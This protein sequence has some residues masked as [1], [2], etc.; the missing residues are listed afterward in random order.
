[1]SINHIITQ[2]ETPVFV[3]QPIDITVNTLTCN[4]L[5]VIGPIS[6]DAYYE[7][8]NNIMVSNQGTRNTCVGLL[9]QSS[10]SNSDNTILGYGSG[11]FIASNR[12]TVLGSSNLTGA[13]ATGAGDKNIIIGTNNYN[14]TTNPGTGNITIGSNCVSNLSMNN[15]L[16]IGDTVST[17]TSGTTRIAP[18]LL[19]NSTHDSTSRLMAHN[20]STGEV[21]VSSTLP[22]KV[23]SNPTTGGL[24]YSTAGT[25]LVVGATATSN[26]YTGTLVFQNIP[27]PVAGLSFINLTLS[28]NKITDSSV[29]NC[30]VILAPE[31]GG[32]PLPLYIAQ[33]A[34]TAGQLVITLYNSTAITLLAGW[35]I[36]LQYIVFS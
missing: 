24:V 36:H 3:N 8:K 25:V 23:Q 31:Q 13:T 20:P 4:E 15:T 5:D 19:T 1:M 27:S 6:T 35:E 32:N 21:T 26:D 29:V 33:L 11:S 34:I 17:I 14:Q 9:S 12:N 16:N 2:S 10:I 28:C 7:I 30:W 18:T 22:F